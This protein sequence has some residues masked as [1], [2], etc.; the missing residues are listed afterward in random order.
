MIK[1]VPDANIILSGFLG[2]HS[3]PRKLINLALAK[4]ITLYGSEDTY[5]EFIEKINLPKFKKYIE[6]QVFTPEKLIVD[7]RTFVNMVEPT[8]AMKTPG[9][10]PDDPDDDMYF[11]TAEACGSQILISGD[12]DL[13]RVKRYKSI[14]VLDVSSFLEI[15][16]KIKQES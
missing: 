7:Y 10:V 3:K 9:I 2:Y 14:R 6:R 12:S 4:K 16:S 5:R 13:L 8:P 1:I 15:Y 11:W